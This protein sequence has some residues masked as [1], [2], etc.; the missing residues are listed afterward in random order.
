MAV[1]DG[2]VVPCQ[3]KLVGVNPLWRPIR[4]TNNKPREAEK[5]ADVRPKV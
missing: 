4:H 1:L 2:Q 3:E 5:A